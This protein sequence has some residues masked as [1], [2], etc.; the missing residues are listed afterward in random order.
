[1]LPRDDLHHNLSVDGTGMGEEG[2]LDIRQRQ[3]T[4]IY[5]LWSAANVQAPLQ[6]IT[7]CIIP[8]ERTFLKS[9]SFFFA[10]CWNFENSNLGG[11][12]PSIPTPTQTHTSYT[13]H[14]LHELPTQL[15]R[16]VL[17]LELCINNETFAVATV[18][19]FLCL[20]D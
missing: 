11:R 6:I 17:I 1:M 18:R 8:P 9:Y 7:V 14:R 10:C 3:G 15:G 12:L 13:Q 2:L 5:W 20:N 16:K 4:N 19:T